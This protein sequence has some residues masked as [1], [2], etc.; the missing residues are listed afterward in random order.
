MMAGLP[1][2]EET[3]S[4]GTDSEG[5][6]SAVPR[7][8]T[9]E[10]LGRGEP[11][12][13]LDDEA[14][15]AIVEG[16]VQRE[17]LQGERVLVLVPDETR[18]F[19][20]ERMMRLL[21]TALRGR[22]RQVDCLVATGTHAPVPDRELRRLAGLDPGE[23][24]VVTN[25]RYDNHHALLEVGRIS[26]DEV[27]SLS[28]GRLR[29]EVPIRI[30]RRVLDADRVL[31]CGPVFPHEVVGFSGGNKY[32]FPGVSGPELIDVSHWLGALLTSRALIGTEGP[33]PVRALIDRAAAAVP[34]QRSCLAAVVD[35]A[36]EVEGVWLGAPEDAWA[37]AAHLAARTHIRRLAHPYRRVLAV[38]APR[39]P[40]MWTGAKAMYKLEPVVA[41][42]G[43]LVVVAPHIREFSA[44][45]GAEIARV[46]YHVRDYFLAHWDDF[47]L[48][49]WKI[50]AHSTHLKGDGTY[51][52]RSGEHPR[53]TVILATGIPEGIVRSHALN[54]RD[55]GT[56]ELQHDLRDPDD[57]TLVV[58]DAGEILF[59]VG[60]GPDPD[61]PLT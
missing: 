55:P 8:G 32:L 46:G 17:H 34:V 19:P 57:E 36:G 60:G 54:W 1:H 40:D 53:I 12:T 13:T 3:A 2:T 27:E 10:V 39:Y 45:H 37:A 49:P 41:D 42:G 4:E 35:G 22:A 25:H 15:S 31:I 28:G 9:R 58:E 14:I 24:G 23:P 29:L 38:P 18:T 48:I 33:N 7:E 50:L 20:T 56:A 6:D 51:D 26:A 47:A 5:T 30:N 52:T 43:E 61:S 11:G 21:R 59:R 44:V 16:W